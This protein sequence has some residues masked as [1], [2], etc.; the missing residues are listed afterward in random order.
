[1]ARMRTIPTVARNLR[2]MRR[3]RKGAVYIELVATVLLLATVFIGIGVIGATTIDIDRDTRSIRSGIDM[4]EVLSEETTTP[5]QDDYDRL[6]QRMVSV[7]SLNSDEDFQI[8][9][10]AVDHDVISGDPVI[11]F[12]G[13]Y[14]TD[15]TRMSRLS[16]ASG[17]VTVNGFDFTVEDGERLLVVEMFRAARGLS[18]D[19]AADRYVKAATYTR[20]P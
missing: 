7:A 2:R 17:L 18:P 15:P 13:A 10:T 12:Q 14:G 1:M 19:P 6:G 5:V 3:A 4:L 8:H 16:I 11:L 9:F 20:V